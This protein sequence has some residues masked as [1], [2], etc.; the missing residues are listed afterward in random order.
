MENSSS[1]MQT[2]ITEDIKNAS[3]NIS[4]QLGDMIKNIQW[5]SMLVVA[6]IA[7]VAKLTSTA[8]GSSH[9]LFIIS[10]ILLFLSITIL[11][12]SNFYA[13]WIKFKKIEELA[14]LKVS[15]RKI[16]LTNESEIIALEEKLIE[17]YTIPH[18]NNAQW[19]SEWGLLAFLFATIFGGLGILF[20]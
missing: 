15:L 16:N 17:Y 5:Y 2:Q 20:S 3:S 9:T 6:E 11:I 4:T 7:G 1:Q 19:L 12:F 14:K 8:Y 10:I 18:R 13:Q